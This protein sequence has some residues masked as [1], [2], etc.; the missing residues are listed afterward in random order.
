MFVRSDNGKNSS[1]LRG[2]GIVSGSIEAQV[3]RG[4]AHS[5]TGDARPEP[6]DVLQDGLGGL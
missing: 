1:R 5:I 2:D 6:E 3:R 4:V